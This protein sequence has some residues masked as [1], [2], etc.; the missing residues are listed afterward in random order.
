M[1]IG[2][3]VPLPGTVPQPYTRKQEANV[4]HHDKGRR[5][6]SQDT[7]PPESAD[8]QPGGAIVVTTFLAVVI[9]LSWFL[10]YILYAVRS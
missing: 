10:I 2:T 9:V 3:Y 7:P 6:E 8:D 5:D 1:G 4:E